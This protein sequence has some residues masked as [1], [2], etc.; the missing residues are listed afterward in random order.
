MELKITV[1][2]VRDVIVINGDVI[3][4]NSLW[5]ILSFF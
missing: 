2:G 3:T 1:S 4:V 5:K